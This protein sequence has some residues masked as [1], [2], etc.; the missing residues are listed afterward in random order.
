MEMDIKGSLS[1]MYYKVVA[2]PI[3]LYAIPIDLPLKSCI[4]VE[5][6]SSFPKMFHPRI[7][8][9]QRI[10]HSGTL[11]GQLTC[12]ASPY[13]PTYYQKKTRFPPLQEMVWKEIDVKD[14]WY[15]NFQRISSTLSNIRF[16]QRKRHQIW[17]LWM[18]GFRI[19]LGAIIRARI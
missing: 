19:P 10:C 8:K 15:C 6:F 12:G 18:R 17:I 2:P 3:T 13:N 5:V 16:Y 14:K 4:D 9:C 7:A 1:M 11:L